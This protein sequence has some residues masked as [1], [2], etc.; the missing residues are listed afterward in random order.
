MNY[1]RG[2]NRRTTA[3]VFFSETPARPKRNCIAWVDGEG[4]LMCVLIDNK[5][6]NIDEL[7][8][9]GVSCVDFYRK[10]TLYL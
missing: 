9:L 4:N 2:Q 7:K 3:T 6:Y 1:R 8:E 5:E 10:D